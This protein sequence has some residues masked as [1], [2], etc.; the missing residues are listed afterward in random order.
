M[1]DLIF[2]DHI[3]RWSFLRGS[4]VV[5][6]TCGKDSMTI[7]IPPIAKPQITVSLHLNDKTEIYILHPDICTFRSNSKGIIVYLIPLG[8]ISQKKF[9]LQIQIDLTLVA[10]GLD[11]FEQTRACFLYLA[12]SELRLCS[13]NPRPGYWSNLPCDW[14]STAWA[15]SE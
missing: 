4:I 10:Q 9:P 14:L 3:E 13:A 1:F 5:V 6:T 15:Y 8:P 12:Q 7:Q 11:Y 2:N